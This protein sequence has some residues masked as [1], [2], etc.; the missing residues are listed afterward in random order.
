M[1]QKLQRLYDYQ[2]MYL[3]Y[4]ILELI[5]IDDNECDIITY[6]ELLEL[7]NNKYAIKSILKQVGIKGFISFGSHNNTLC[8]TLSNTIINQLSNQL[9]SLHLW[10]DD[11]DFLYV[12][13]TENDKLIEF[14]SF[15]LLNEICKTAQ[16][17]QCHFEVN[18]ESVWFDEC[19]LFIEC[20]SKQLFIYKQL[21][22]IEIEINDSTNEITN[23]YDMFNNTLKV[24]EFNQ[25]LNKIVIKIK[26]CVNDDFCIIVYKSEFEC[27]DQDRKFEEKLNHH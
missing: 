9:F 15:L 16:L 12:L 11:D 26:A 24:K 21:N 13:D 3:K 6:N 5:G 20:I 8:N 7:F 23:V 17:K 10:S 22:W 14:N 19:E 25:K 18:R 4:N 2:V 27:K 1:I